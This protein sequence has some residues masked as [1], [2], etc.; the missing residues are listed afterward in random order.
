[1]RIRRPFM[2]VLPLI[3][4][5]LLVGSGFSVWY[6]VEAKKEKD[7]EVSIDVKNYDEGYFGDLDVSF[8]NVGEDDYAPSGTMPK[9]VISQRTI[10]FPEVV[11]LSFKWNFSSFNPND[12]IFSFNY[13]ITFREDF[14]SYFRFVLPV[15]D[16]SSSIKGKWQNDI[17]GSEI[18]NNS[19]STRSLNVSF[20]Y[21]SGKSP[22][23]VEAYKDL[24]NLL[25][26]SKDNSPLVLFEFYVVASRGE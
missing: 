20:S 1:M 7:E 21:K 24:K 10:E 22:K 23:T 11:N 9:L 16:V 2:L 15:S 6:F 26:N 19:V 4:S 14:A 5:L 3:A 17:K 25:T 8:G 18:V 12:F 13:K